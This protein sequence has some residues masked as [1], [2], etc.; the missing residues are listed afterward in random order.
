MP[1]HFETDGCDVFLGDLLVQHLL[2]G[3]DLLQALVLHLELPLELDDL[4]EAQLRGALQVAFPLRALRGGARLLEL[5]LHASDRVDAF[6]LL[7]PVRAHRSRVLLEVGELAFEAIETLQRGRVRLLLERGALDLELA[8]APFHLVDLDRHRI[9]LDPEPGGRLIDEVDGLV[10]EEPARHVAIGQDGGRDERGILDPNAVVDLVSLLQAAEDRDR[11]LHRR[12]LHEDRLEP[13][14]ERCI[15]LDV[16]AVLVEGGGSHQPELSSSEHRLQHVPGVHRSLGSAGADDRM[17]LV[18]EGD[19]L[20]TGIRDLLQ[21][22]LE[23]FLELTAVLRAGDHRADVERDQPLV[24][25]RL[26]NVAVDDPLRQPLDDRGLPD[27]GLPDEDRVVLRPPGQHLDHTPDLLVT[28]DHRIELALPRLLGEVPAETLERLER[29][30]RVLRGDAVTP[31]DLGERGQHAFAGEPGLAEHAVDRTLPLEHREEDVLGRD[32]L[33][34]QLLGLAARGLQHARRRRRQ[35]DLNPFGVDLR[36]RVE[37]LIDRVAELLRY[38]PELMQ[39]REHDALG[40]GE[41]RVQHVL[42]LD[43]LMVSGRGLLMRFL[44][45]RLRLDRQPVEFHPALF[46]SKSPFVMPYIT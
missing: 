8:D 21:D 22:G 31:S 27:T 17:H 19:D 6:L 12:R 42:G 9:D 25:Q 43:L 30:L 15:L 13:S 40:V 41:E 11:V 46:S 45:R 39:Q 38:H 35:T 5:R 14:F 4:G 18:D 33:V 44:E 29:L 26:R 7:L 10:R 1:V 20:A 3:L 37:G 2:V 23:P 16:L 34:R 24:L 36:L 28:P 32:V